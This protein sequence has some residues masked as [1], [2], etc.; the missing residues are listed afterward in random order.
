VVVGG[1]PGGLMAAETLARAGVR[2]TVYDS[3]PSVGRKFLMAGRGGLNITHSEPFDS[4]LA[5]YRAATPHLDAALRSFTPKDMR[6]WCAGLGQ[7]TFVGSSGRVFPQSFKASPLLRAWLRRL[8]DLG[9]EFRVRHRFE[10]W[11][12]DGDL[13]F[14]SPGGPVRTR[15]DVTVLAT[16]GASWPR[17]GSDGEWAELLRARGVEVSPL[18]PSNCGFEANWSD[19]LKSRFAGAPLKPVALAFA[20]EVVRG[21]TIVTDYGL[22]GGALYSLSAPL[23]ERI[24]QDDRAVLTIDLRPDVDEVR[25]VARLSTP[26]RGMSMATFLR[27]AAGLSPVAA[28]ILREAGSLPP[29][30]VELARRIKALQ[31]TLTGIRPLDRAISTAGGVSFAALDGNLM[32]R[33]LPG[34]FCCGE[35]LD[36]EAPTGG[37]LLQ[38][39]F[40]TGKAAASG[41]LNWIEN[42]P[43][44]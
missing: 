43:V 39:T 21:E 41:A 36:W 3:M 27:K 4:F 15:A 20:G 8:T 22:E 32:L 10:G 35:M 11:T 29:G 12:A 25:L 44:Y 14:A 6:E 28:S 23:R 30:A 26:R 13:S 9:V 16:G 18:L 2:V 37:Y 7:E 42:N 17:L 31:V 34:V 1:G 19:V 33:T 40:A 38:A 24:L 5:R